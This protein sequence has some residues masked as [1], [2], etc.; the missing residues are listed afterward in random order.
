MISYSC[1]LT[2]TRE[3][4]KAFAVTFVRVPDFPEPGPIRESLHCPLRAL[5]AA[6]LDKNGAWSFL[7]LTTPEKNCIG[8]ALGAL[9]LPFNQW[10]YC[11]LHEDYP[12]EIAA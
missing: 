4:P 1:R 7:T 8:K 11:E 2:L 6:T 5:V 10:V 3:S 9:N 12:N